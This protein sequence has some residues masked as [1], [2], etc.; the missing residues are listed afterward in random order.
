[1]GSL[2]AWGRD[3]GIMWEAICGVAGALLGCG[4]G[5]FW[6]AAFGQQFLERERVFRR[7]AQDPGEP[8]GTWDQASKVLAAEGGLLW[9]GFFFYVIIGALAGVAIGGGGGLVMGALLGLVLAGFGL[10]ARAGAVALRIRLT[11]T[12]GP[13]PGHALLGALGGGWLGWLLWRRWSPGDGHA[14][15]GAVILGLVF[16][17]LVA[18]NAWQKFSR[19]T[20]KNGTASQARAAQERIKSEG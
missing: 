10:S 12:L 13:I 14:Y 9:F 4:V 19:S 3:A 1:M 5:L 18:A 20:D 2:L 8:G 15:I 6:H 17:L 16:A 7:V 11:K